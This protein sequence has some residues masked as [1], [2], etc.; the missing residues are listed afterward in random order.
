[1]LR[2]ELWETLMRSTCL[3]CEEAVIRPGN[4]ERAKE[5]LLCPSCRA[6]LQRKVDY[7]S[8]QIEIEMVNGLRPIVKPQPW[9]IP[10][11]WSVVSFFTGGLVACI[12]H[13]IG[14]WK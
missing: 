6:N 12:L 1:V 11:P 14:W 13:W 4:I 5:W 8:R 3:M 9:Y 10:D 7:A 2:R